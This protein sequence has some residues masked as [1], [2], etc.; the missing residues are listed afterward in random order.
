MSSTA[1]EREEG[2]RLFRQAWIQGVGRHY[3]GTPKESYIKPWEQMAPWEQ[4]SA[5]VVY[6]QARAFMLAGLREQRLTPLTREQGG[7]FIRIAWVAQMFRHFPDPKPAYVC[8]WDDPLMQQWEKE[9][10]MDVFEA[11]AAAVRVT[12]GPDP[13]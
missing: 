6:Q 1:E 10:D 7:R 11:I 4:E 3:P 5:M 8:D 9:V 2:G 12:T 13:A